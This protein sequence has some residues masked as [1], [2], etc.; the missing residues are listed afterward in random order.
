MSTENPAAKAGGDNIEEQAREQT[1]QKQVRI[2]IDE[3]GMRTDYANAFR[4]DL[5]ILHVINSSQLG[6]P[7]VE[8]GMPVDIRATLD[9][10]EE[11]VNKALELLA[12]E[13]RRSVSSVRVA[14]KIGSPAYEIVHFAEENKVDLVVMGTHGFTGLKHLIMGST[15]ENVVR[16]ASCPV[17]TVRSGRE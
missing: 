5:T 12:E 10:I 3:T 9:N 14:S 8:E 1:G 2:R 4:S 16:T 6:Y 15:A 7:S 13:C 17:L 11:S